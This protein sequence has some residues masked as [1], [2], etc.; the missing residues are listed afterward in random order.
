LRTPDFGRL[1][2]RYDELRPADERWQEVVAAMD[3]AAGLAGRVLDVGCGTG[4][5][6]ADLAARGVRTFGIDASPEMLAVARRKAPGAG[7]KEGRAE[8]LPFRNGWFDRVVFQLSLHLVDRA[9]ALAEARRVLAPGGR[10]VVATFDPVHFRQFWLNRYLPSLERIDRARFPTRER[11][12]A[13]LAEAGFSP[14]RFATLHQELAI[15]RETALTRLRERHISTF[16]LIGDE[17]YEAGL[18]RAEQELPPRVEYTRDF[19]IAVADR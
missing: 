9:R 10:V 11:L 2:A 16:D 15:D 8:A 18:A 4:N 3:E 7:L 14:P 19:L 6:V 1:A 17:E 5:L 13:E 12:S